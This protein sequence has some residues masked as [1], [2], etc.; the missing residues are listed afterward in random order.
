MNKKLFW[1]LLG[2]FFLFVILF[3]AMFAPIIRPLMDLSSTGVSE[4]SDI[5]KWGYTIL[6]PL[7]FGIMAF[8]SIVIFYRE[9]FSI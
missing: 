4:C 1:R 3:P 9:E 8:L 6:A 5:Q 2:C 7:I